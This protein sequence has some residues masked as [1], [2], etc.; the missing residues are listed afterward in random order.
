[1]LLFHNR[2]RR[3]LEAAYGSTLLFTYILS[4]ISLYF[5][6][7]PAESASNLGINY[8]RIADNLPTP[9]Q[10]VAILQSISVT[11]TRIYDAN[12]AVIKAFAN[13]GISIIVGIGNEDV[14]SLTSPSLAFSWVE[15][16]VAVYYPAT[17]MIGIA[18]GNEALS[19]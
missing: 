10:A 6:A 11:K 5:L 18:V 9:A 14:S 16:N 19:G 15:T 4:C 13:S 12:A 1:M 7:N 2:R 8:G 17:N 3:R